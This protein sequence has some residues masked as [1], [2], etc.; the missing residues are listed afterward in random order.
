MDMSPIGAAYDQI[1][2]EQDRPCPPPPPS[3]H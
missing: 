2:Q 1:T 3:P